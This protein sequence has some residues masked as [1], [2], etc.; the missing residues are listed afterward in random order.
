M[1]LNTECRFCKLC[2][3][4]KPESSHQ[5]QR[6][7]LDMYQVFRHSRWI[8]DCRSIHLKTCLKRRINYHN[9]VKIYLHKTKSEVSREYFIDRYYVT[10]CPVIGTVKKAFFGKDGNLIG[11]KQEFLDF[12]IPLTLFTTL[13]TDILMFSQGL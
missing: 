8:R 9:F 10:G 12:S 3:L 6:L 2:W 11:Q 5:P 13:H 1:E 7:G 4:S